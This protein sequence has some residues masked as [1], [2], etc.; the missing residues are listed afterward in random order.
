MPKMARPPRFE[1]GTLCL[2]DRQNAQFPPEIRGFSQK[3]KGVR[4]QAI[5]CRREGVD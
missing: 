3:V 4:F 1:R 2:E 5:P